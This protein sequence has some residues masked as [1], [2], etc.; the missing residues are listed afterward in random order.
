[1][2]NRVFV[3]VQL[4]QTN[5]SPMGMDFFCAEVQVFFPVFFQVSCEGLVTYAFSVDAVVVVV[6]GCS[7]PPISI[8]AASQTQFPMTSFDDLQ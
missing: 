5:V 8:Q 3:I 7:V 4:I 2:K 1:M 6:V